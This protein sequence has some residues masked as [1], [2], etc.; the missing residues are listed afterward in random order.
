MYVCSAQIL[1]LPI[2]L[3]NVGKKG[4]FILQKVAISNHP[5]VVSC[6]GSSIP[7]NSRVEAGSDK[8][9]KTM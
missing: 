7:L 4:E 1:Q 6:L 8:L 9:I 2:L 5:Q 3:L